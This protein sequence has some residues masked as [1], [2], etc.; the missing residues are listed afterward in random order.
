MYLKEVRKAQ[1]DKTD[2]GWKE[3]CDVD[4]KVGRRFAGSEAPATLDTGFISSAL[5]K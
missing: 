3:L 4:S 2:K 1:K 5:I